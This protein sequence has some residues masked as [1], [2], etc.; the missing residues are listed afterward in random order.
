MA[1]LVVGVGGWAA[2]TEL[3]GAVIAP[4]DVIVEGN[5]KDVQHPTGGVVA[6]L[7]VREGQLVE[8]GDVVLRLDATTTRANL[9]IISNNLN[10]LY[11]R[12]ARLEAERDGAAD[13]SLL[14]ELALR[15]PAPDIE[16]VMGS[17]RR[18][19]ANRTTARNGQKDQ[20][21]ERVA[22]LTE[23]I[24]GHIAQQAAKT[25][26]IE[27]IESELVGVRSLYEKGLTPLDRLNN[28]QR[29][30]ARLH[31]E[32]GALIAAVA[33]ARGKISEVQ[34]QLLQV[35]QTMRSEVATEL[36]DVSARE[37]ELLEREVAAQDQ[38]ARIDVRSPIG[39]LVHQLAVHT[40]GGVIKPADPVMRIVPQST[41]LTIEARVTAKDIDQIALDQSTT[42]RLTAFNRNTTPQLSGM[43]TRISGDAV[44][45]ER[46]GANYYRVGISITQAEL[47]KL[48]KLSLVPGMPVECYIR[49][50]DRTVLS[51]IT[52]PLDDHT[53]R[54][55]RED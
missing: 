44:K 24:R 20:L 37:A 21:H 12:Q 15:L 29:A 25:E 35:D 54:V 28:L 39:G 13:V 30:A 14:P 34:L 43:V 32:R 41:K 51:Y 53:H 33:E 4:G 16:K 52:K 48:G 45:D 36:R 6:A 26:E 49:T 2:T 40:V 5:V 3:S 42:L 1:F 47:A 11:A 19:F 10:S 46:S 27:L 17:E 7:L 8:A 50:G 22:Q 38:L 55:F 23:Q 9:L 18:L 31:G